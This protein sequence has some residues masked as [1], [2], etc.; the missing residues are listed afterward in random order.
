[1]KL[2]AGS[3]ATLYLNATVRVAR[4]NV[5]RRFIGLPYG[6]ADLDPAAA[7]MLAEAAVPAADVV[8]I[9]SDSGCATVGLAVSYPLD[10]D[11]RPVGHERCQPIGKAAHEAG[12]VGLAVRSAAPGM[13]TTD[14]E[15]VWFRFDG[16]GPR[17]V[18]VR[19]F[20]EWYP[21]GSGASPL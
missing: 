17:L 16:D 12:Q 11:G 18:R 1:V 21:P 4:A 9:V 19:R 20:A 3:F 7:P 8:D 13:S 14:E 6:P 5:D 10:S 2:G 15:L